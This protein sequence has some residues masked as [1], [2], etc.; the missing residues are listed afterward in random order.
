[1]V[2]KNHINGE[3]V[4]SESNFANRNPATGEIICQVAEAD[5]TAVDRAVWAARQALR[6]PWGSMR[7]AERVKR[8]HCSADAIEARFDDVV[9]AEITD[10]GKPL[11]QAT[12]IDIPRG[13]ANFRFFA[14]LSGSL[15][16]EAFETHT[17]DERHALNY[18]VRRALGVVGVISPWNL[19]FL[20]LTWKL[21]P[22]LAAGNTIVAKPSEE[23]PSSAALLAEVMAEHLPKGVFNL[24]NGFG[25]NSAGEFLASHPD[26]D[27][28][29]FTG[30]SSTGTAIMKSSA[31]SLK[32]LSFELG[33]KNAAIVFADADFAK[34][35][36][37]VAKA[38]FINCGQVC[39]CT[40]R[41]YVHRSIFDKFLAALKK[42][43]EAI[44]IGLPYEDGTQMGPLVSHDHRDKVLS[45]FDL[46]VQE[47]ATVIAGG[48]VPVFDDDRR[49]GAFVEPTIWTGLPE[50]SRTVKEEIF[51]PVCHIAPFDEEQQAVAMANDSRYGLAAAVWTE[52]LARAHR[53]AAQMEVGVAWVNTWYLRDLRTPFGGSKMSGV[54]REGGLHSLHFYSQPTNVC[55]DLSS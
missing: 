28:I 48:K 47:G 6:G 40:E 7:P 32:E 54:G 39:L 2:I 19:P 36:A 53:V 9:A 16:T 20:L 44:Q 25:Q 34:A 21:A 30:E 8:L 52:N 27:A 3:F 22:A 43:A 11:S 1:M 42:K 4:G 24:V 23:T 31:A 41:V 15:D 51:G 55:I 5:K 50:T 38:A 35:V 26:V 18:T 13:A 10:T 37:G 29:T 33:G 14:D 12:S 49:D 17:Q 45:Y 46:A